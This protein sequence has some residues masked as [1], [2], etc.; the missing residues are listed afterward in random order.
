MLPHIISSAKK[1]KRKV[2]V[3]GNVDTEASFFLTREEK[4]KSFV[5]VI[6]VG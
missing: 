5:L 4:L 2:A 3:E 6:P 1:V